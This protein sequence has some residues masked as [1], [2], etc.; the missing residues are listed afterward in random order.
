MESFMNPLNEAILNRNY[1]IFYKK[2][3]E[4]LSLHYYCYSLLIWSMN[5]LYLRV[6][7]KDTPYLKYEYVVGI[8]QFSKNHLNK[9]NFYM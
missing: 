2:K 5:M 6:K 8:C 3:Q 4:K 9:T 7:S 1:N